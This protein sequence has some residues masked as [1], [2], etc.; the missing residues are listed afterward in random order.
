MRVQEYE[1]KGVA[2]TQ[3]MQRAA[4]KVVQE[5][6]RLRAL[7]ARHGVLRDEVDSFLRVCEQTEAPSS[8]EPEA[9]PSLM[10]RRSSVPNN[11]YPPV[12][13][14]PRSLHIQPL[15]PAYP[16]DYSPHPSP[17]SRA[18]VQ[19]SRQSIQPSRTAS[20]CGP[21][22]QCGPRNQ[23]GPTTTTTTPPQGDSHNEATVMSKPFEITRQTESYYASPTESDSSSPPSRPQETQPVSTAPDYAPPVRPNQGCCPP[24]KLQVEVT[25]EDPACP[26]TDDCFCPPTV[27]MLPLTNRP[28]IS[29]DEMS[30]ETAA[31]II[32]QMRGEEDDTAA[33]RSLGCG[34]GEV[35]SVRNT[36]LLQLLDEQ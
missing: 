24:S 25:S 26:N 11:P 14:G 30:C 5:N 6:E 21:A 28:S 8:A 13:P 33:R 18:P 20:T 16:M 34:P 31:T 12:N 1:Q 4:R 3:D 32:A 36:F 7:L 2:A 17:V 22:T 10:S 23:C 27:T 9:M 35:C 19:I 29:N 15:S